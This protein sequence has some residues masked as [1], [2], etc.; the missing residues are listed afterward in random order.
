NEERK[1]M[2]VMSH[3]FILWVMQVNIKYDH[4]KLNYRILTEKK[5][6][7]LNYDL[8]AKCD[9]F[10]SAVNK[11]YGMEELYEIKMQIKKVEN[12]PFMEVSFLIKGENN[13]E[14]TL[15]SYLNSSEIQVRQTP[16]GI[17]SSF[18]IQ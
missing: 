5:L 16:S 13:L 4:I 18:F 14:K 1:L 15:S 7:H 2:H 9:N 11:T 12:S 17:V 6:Q 3:E 10:I 8:T